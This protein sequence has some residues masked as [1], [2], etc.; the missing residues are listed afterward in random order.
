MPLTPE[1]LASANRNHGLVSL[2]TW[3]E[4]GRSRSSYYR[5]LES[6]LLVRVVRDVAALAGTRPSTLQHIAA[7]VLALGPGAGASH[8]SAAWLWGAA[9]RGDEPVELTRS[10][11]HR[12]RV[13]PGYVVHR[14]LEGAP[15]RWVP[16][17][18][19]P[20]T[21]PTRTLLDLGAS[22][23][24]A[25]LPALESFV[26][27]GH[28]TVPMVTSA[29][30]W[31][32]RPG[33]NGIGPLVAA[34]ENVMAEGAVT[35]SELESVMRRLLRHAGIDG[36]AF[37]PRIEGFEV[38]FALFDGRLI[39]EV[40]GWLVH[41]ASRRTWLD[42]LDRDLILTAAGWLVLRLSWSMVT[43]RPEV[44]AARIRSTLVRRRFMAG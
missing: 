34:L 37:H 27:A 35:D 24:A 19:V 30:R 4:L 38:D 44:A 41:G 8:R 28:V 26:R 1:I 10:T 3:L 15:V 31:R 20:A 13:G 22:D 29:L 43:R 6:G 32:R 23:A 25:V 17:S 5:S 40:D 39:I 7:G 11:A 16:R 14:P 18:G 12:S 2:R 42:D 21:S 9:V 33:R 36:W